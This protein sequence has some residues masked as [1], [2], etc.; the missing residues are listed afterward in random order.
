LQWYVTFTS[1]LHSLRNELAV[2][3]LTLH[4]LMGPLHTTR[5]NLSMTMGFIFQILP[6]RDK[7]LVYKS[8]DNIHGL[9][10]APRTSG[11]KELKVR[12]GH[13]GWHWSGENSKILHSSYRTV[14]FPIRHS[15][16]GFF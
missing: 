11:R 10:D 4:I 5:L 6:K 14:C 2:T 15:L 1:L 7:V 16:T 13:R 8:S 3:E 9:G 12:T